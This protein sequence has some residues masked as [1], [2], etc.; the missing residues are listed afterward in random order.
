MR[1][2][3][4]QVMFLSGCRNAAP[5]FR[6]L[7]LGVGPHLESPGTIPSLIVLQ[8]G[9]PAGNGCPVPRMQFERAGARAVYDRDQVLIFAFELLADAAAQV[10]QMLAF[11]RTDTSGC[12]DRMSRSGDRDRHVIG[13]IGEAQALFE[14]AIHRDH[15]APAALGKPMAAYDPSVEVGVWHEQPF[16]VSGGRGASRLARRRAEW[17]DSSYATSNNPAAPM[18]PPMHIVTSTYLTPRRL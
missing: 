9:Q 8:G 16:A 11:V 2:V 18:P 7:A 17:T 10:E 12:V 15:G 13:I 3:D 5:A 6:A 14:R 1:N 4:R